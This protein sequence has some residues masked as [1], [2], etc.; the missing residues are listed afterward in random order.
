[1]LE[2]AVTSTDQPDAASTP[3][4]KEKESGC[5]RKRPPKVFE[6]PW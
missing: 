2:C 1:M 4:Y 6:T 5:K 3:T